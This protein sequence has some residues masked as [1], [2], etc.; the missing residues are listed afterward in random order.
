MGYTISFFNNGYGIQPEPIT[1]IE[2][3]T[4]DNLPVLKEDGFIF[5]GWYLDEELTTKAEVGTELTSDIT[6]YA[7]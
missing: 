7:C 1:N 5:E 6:L 4:A 3:L 2:I